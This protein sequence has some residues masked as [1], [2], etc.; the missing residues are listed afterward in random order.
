MSHPLVDSRHPWDLTVAEAKAVQE[1]LA[2]RVEHAPLAAPP[3]LVAGAD[4][5]YDKGS[6]RFFAAVVVL[7]LPDL[8]VVDQGCTEG[9]VDFPYVPGLLSFRE[10]PL[11]ERA[12]ER[13][14]HR[15]DVL[16]T[17][18]HGL[19]HMRRFGLACH[20]G[21]RLDLP[22]LGCAKS[23]L[24]G[25]CGEPGPRSGDRAPILLDGD[26][27]GAVLRTRDRVSPVYVSVG[28]RITLD[29]ACEVVLASRTRYRLPETTRHAHNLVNE[30]RRASKV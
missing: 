10:A 23:R 15:P 7:R 12:F 21:V 9:D 20:L 1:A 14:T 27:V 2:D 8:E 18:G 30:M 25:E 13:L 3:T 29:E 4:I 6:K 11:V 24:C 26:E 5:S 19:A 28:H 16:I 17:D 22:T